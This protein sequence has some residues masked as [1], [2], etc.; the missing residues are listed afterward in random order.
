MKTYTK[1]KNK[2]IV[3]RRV[4]IFVTNIPF[5]L[6]LGFVKTKYKCE[7]T[8]SVSSLLIASLIFV[9]SS[10]IGSSLI[11]FSIIIIVCVTLSYL[12]AIQLTNN[13]PSFV[14]NPRGKEINS[15]YVLLL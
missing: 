10:I 12:L 8:L 9:L 7:I 1:V 5:G 6:Y 11:H 3:K 14:L 4:S 13:V 2:V 15:F